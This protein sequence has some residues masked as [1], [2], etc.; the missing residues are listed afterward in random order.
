M[1]RPTPSAVALAALL[2]AATALFAVAQARIHGTIKDENGK[3]LEGVKV[4]VSQEGTAF[5]DEDI[6]D[7]RGE[8]A[9][10]LNDSTQPYTYTFTKEGYLSFKRSYKIPIN[11]NEKHDF[12]MLSLAEARKRGVA[13]GEPSA[14]GQAVEIFNQGAEAAQMGDTATARAKFQAAIELDPNLAAAYLALASLAY[15]EENWAEAANQAEKARAIKGDDVKALRILVES[16]RQ[17]GDDA[18]AAAAAQALAATDP[19]AGAADLY[20]QG[21]RAYN[22]GD[23]A[24]AQTLF[25]Q[26]LAADG[27][28]ADSH[29]MLG[30]CL[31]GT[32]AA[33]A[34]EHLE[35]FLRLAPDDPDAPTAREMLQYLK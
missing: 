29:Y 3:P 34:R 7:P 33:K 13:V 27:D 4:T 28:H 22:G 23:T 8:Y 15:T 26:A 19:A 24:S 17:L 10:T 2:G 5:H 20:N 12:E 9:I 18:K 16:Y 31:A 30:L 11:T 32:D 6:T 25:E 14:A 1:Y 35:T 21:V